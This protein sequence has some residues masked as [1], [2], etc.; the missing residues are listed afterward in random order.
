MFWKKATGLADGV[1][2]YSFRLA[3]AVAKWGKLDNKDHH[4]LLFQSAS[5][6]KSSATNPQICN[7]KSPQ[8]EAHWMSMCKKKAYQVDS[9]LESVRGS[10]VVPPESPLT[11]EFWC[12]HFGQQG[13]V[14]RSNVVPKDN[15]FT[16]SQQLSIQTLLYLQAFGHNFNVKFRPAIWVPYWALGRRR[17][18]KVAK[19]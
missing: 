17:W 4:K 7:N 19:L 1:E 14:S 10:K 5:L 12:P 11:S 9:Y 16:T 13:G 8:F 15:T 18:S 3:P 2:Y 6:Y